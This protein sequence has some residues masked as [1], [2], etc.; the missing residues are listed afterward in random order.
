MKQTI[1][2]MIKSF[3]LLLCT[4][5]VALAATVTIVPSGGNSYAVMGESM[6]G[7]AGIDLTISYDSASLSSPSVN[8]GAL[9]SGAMFLANANS[10]GSIKIA[11]I[12][13]TVF[14]GNGQIASI[15]FGSQTGSG[16]IAGVNASMIDI[17]GKPMSVQTA[18]APAPMTPLP[19]K[20]SETGAGTSTGTTSSVST[21]S[22]TT[23][24]PAL[25]SSLG[26]VNLPADTQLP[27]VTAPSVAATTPS[28]NRKKQLSRRQL[29]P[30]RL[31]LP[32]IR[33]PCRL[34]T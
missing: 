16:G 22:S 17:S 33:Q 28:P 26:S 21:T 2:I 23:A 14:K 12:T 25:S 4:V 24:A 8:Q 13:T 3:L 11:V 31:L 6:D 15:S 7:V 34:L 5:S 30:S 20:A 18:I 1:Q 32:Q 19:S 10:P 9:V 27:N 29:L